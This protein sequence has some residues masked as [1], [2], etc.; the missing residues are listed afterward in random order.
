MGKSSAPGRSGADGTSVFARQVDHVITEP[1]CDAVKWKIRELDV[2]EEE[3]V[4]IAVFDPQRGG[5]VGP[6]VEFPDLKRLTTNRLVVAL[7][8]GDF[9]EQPVGAALVG[10][11]FGAVGEQNVSVEG[12]PVPMLAT[13]KLA[14]FGFAEFCCRRHEC[15]LV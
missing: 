14:E 13:G 12:V 5:I 1:K 4:V 2:P 8:D 15:L 3:Q 6:H 9:V 7:S 11:V 10:D